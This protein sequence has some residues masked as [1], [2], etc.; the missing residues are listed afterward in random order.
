MGDPAGAGRVAGLV[1]AAGGGTRFGAGPKLLADLGGR[2]LLEWAVR[3][4]CAVPELEHIVVV[5]G[6]HAEAILAAVRFGRADVVVC[7]QWESG[8]AAS[9]RRG[10]AA[11][12]GAGKV[13]VTLGDAPLITP[14]VI[15]R[16]LD[17][18]PLTRATYG[19]RPGHPVVLGRAQM[20]AL[21]SLSGD[22]GARDLL[23]G[24]PVI[25]VGHLCSG[26]DVDTPEDLEEVRGEARAVI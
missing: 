7:E 5:L 14:A 22:R 17:E 24:G 2:P 20:E 4:Q 6:A 26:R 18:P 11:V 10:L 9:L 12:S 16:F 8:Q 23:G 13:I 19:G 1:L 15:R 21:T 25:E 3:A